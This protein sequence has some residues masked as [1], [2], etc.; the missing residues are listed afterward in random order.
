MRIGI[1]I[2]EASAPHAGKGRYTLYLVKELLKLDTKNDY[3]LYAYKGT[4]TEDFAD[5]ANAQIREIPS[6]G[7]LWHLRVARAVRGGEVDL[8]FAPTSFIIPAL[9]PRKIPTLI[10]VHDLVAFLYPQYHQRKATIIER[11][12]LRRALSRARA[13]VTPSQ[14]TRKDLHRL[15]HYS[16]ERIHVTPLGVELQTLDSKDSNKNI[17]SNLGTTQLPKDFILTVGGLHPRKNL[18]Q[19]LTV[20]PRL[21]KK[22]LG[23]T[24]VMVG[25]D[26]WKSEEVQRA[27]VSC[28]KLVMRVPRCSEAEL[29]ML[30]TRA[31][32]L[33]FPSLYE[34]FG[35]PP[36]EAM[37]H[38]CPVV[39]SSSSSLPEVCGDACIYINPLNQESAFTAIDTILSSPEVAA[40]LSAAGKERAKAFT[41]AKTAR[42]TLD[43]LR[44]CGAH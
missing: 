42:A 9:L 35:L 38:G 8:F 1:D 40:Q 15:F 24:L 44:A 41:W 23:L 21:A 7:I 13:V 16:S 37:A 29:G 43:V 39:A 28:E 30:Y 17:S 32:A 20:L 25:D 6:H 26:G 14:S 2:R 36:L 34:G 4:N 27:L 33:V 18:I 11:L 31:R 22:Y 5:Y 19:V 10:T 3:V 12:S